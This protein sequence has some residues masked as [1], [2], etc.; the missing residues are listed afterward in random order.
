[1]R[2]DLQGATADL[3]VTENTPLAIRT[4]QIEQCSVHPHS[5]V[6][7]TSITANLLP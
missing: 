5:A 6:G 7:S 1:M 4:N 3:D 2:L